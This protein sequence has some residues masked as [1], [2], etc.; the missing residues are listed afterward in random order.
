MTI[1]PDTPPPVPNAARLRKVWLWVGI[2]M[3]ILGIA[4]LVMPVASS[5][6]VGILV[7]WLLFI[8]GVIA[9]ASAFSFRGTGLF[10]LQLP[11]GLIPLIAGAL[12]IVFPA[13]GLV[14][15]T[16]L[17]GLVFLLT[18]FA[19]ISFAFWARPAPGWGWVLASAAISIA[20]G[21]YILM[22]L[23][24]ASAVLLGILVGID[25][26]STGIAMVLIAT[27]VRPRP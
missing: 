21:G 12:L 24:A 11:A 14:A 19:Q 25:F 23:S 17:L 18:G 27:M 10:A 20:L 13:Q 22:A 3:I 6:L 9:V 7:G 5:L 15:L 26:L 2:A 1:E 16:V 4:A 8:S